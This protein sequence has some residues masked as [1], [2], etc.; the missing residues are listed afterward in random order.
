MRTRFGTVAAM[1]AT[2]AT[3]A[4]DL[5]VPDLNNPGIDQL[6]DDPTPSAV[7]AACTGLL[8]GNRRNTAQANGVV[9]QLGILGREAYNF[10]QADPRFINE[11]L[12]GQLNP[13]SP[14]GGNF[15]ALPYANLRLA[16]IVLVATERVADFS[17]TERAAIRGF[18]RTIMA[19][20]L[21]E[22]VNTR[23]SNGGVI[24]VGRRLDEALPPL[25]GRDEM[26]ARIAELLDEGATELAA[27]GGVFPFAL[28]SGYR[29]FDTPAT[30]LPFNRAVR[31]RVAAY[32]GDHA[33][34][35]SALED[36]FLDD[37]ATTVAELA[38]GVY[39]S[40]STGAGDQVNNLIN[41]NL[42][43]HPSIET[44]AQLQA[45]GA[46]DDR[47]TRKTVRVDEAGAAGLSSD[48][49]FAI[50]P[51]PSAP[52]PII[53]NEELLLLRAEA[54]WGLRDLDLA[55]ADLD[56]VRTVSG[57]LP[58]LEGTPTAD[59]IED[60]LLYNRRYSL[61]FE[62]GHSLIDARRFDR[63]TDLPLD[64]GTM[65]HVYNVRFP[66]PSA[67]CDARPGEPRC[68]LGSQ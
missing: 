34:I 21:L 16:S 17:T 56:R 39:H 37:G 30:F 2:L 65:P 24:E 20:D 19:L 36:S 40:Y 47:F 52:V 10:D 18:V 43:V 15:W 46:P 8:I 7:L 14:F 32:L 31:A 48:L 4:C 44:G 11:L 50:Y 33:T 29:G 60:E 64:Q 3:A 38:V 26:L 12:T 59:D 27:G 35:L 67:E 23:D 5:E 49:R 22:I 54:Y 13:S 42:F 41:P 25:V 57:G 66:I 51:G 6:E 1:L 68:A 55:V 53:R 58:P 62:G 61:L 9:A 63:V 28:S 45:G